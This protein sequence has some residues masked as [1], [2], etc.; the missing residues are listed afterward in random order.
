M[1]WQRFHRRY[2]IPNTLSV[3][4]TLLLVSSNNDAAHLETLRS[5][6]AMHVH[7]QK[8]VDR[9]TRQHRSLPKPCV[10][11]LRN[12]GIHTSKRVQ[13][14][15]IISRSRPKPYANFKINFIHYTTTTLSE[16]KRAE[17]VTAENSSFEQERTASSKERQPMQSTTKLS[18][19]W[20]PIGQT[21][22]VK[23][24]VG[25]VVAVVEDAEIGVGAMEAP[26]ESRVVL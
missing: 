5:N 25:E 7:T 4:Q 19:E 17:N 21:A 2:P 6:G 24:A 14:W 12:R 3:H 1:F 18:A 26:T 9:Y 10:T 15:N 8:M 16:S 11:R 13:K 20:L 22:V 23:V